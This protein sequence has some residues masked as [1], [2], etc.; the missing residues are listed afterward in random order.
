MK[1]AIVLGS[2][3]A[4]LALAAPASAQT[5]MQQPS[6]GGGTGKFCLKQKA[7]GALNCTYASMSQCQQASN[8]GNEG[9]CVEN[10]KAT[11]GTAPKKN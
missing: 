2:L 3:L 1:K 11:T 7:S 9:D 10:P 6:A 4:A 5:P 8:K